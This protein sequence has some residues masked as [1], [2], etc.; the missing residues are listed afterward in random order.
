MLA[1]LH[2]LWFLFTAASGHMQLVYPP[3]FGAENNPHRTDP[4]DEF[5]QYPF[6]CCGRATEFPCR[7]Y[8]K[9]LG[10]P[11][12][13]ST[14][15]WAAGSR[16]QWNISGIGNHY[17]GS[18][19]VGFSVDQGKTFHVATSYQGNCPKRHGGNDASG[20]TFDFTVPADIPIGDA[21][22]AWTWYNREQEFN[23]NCAAVSI[24]GDFATADV[25]IQS[26][27]NASKQ[28]SL[29]SQIYS[30]DGCICTCPSQEISKRAMHHHHHKGGVHIQERR[31]V[32]F[33][34]RPGMLFADINNGCF[35]PHTTA[36]TRFADPG[37]DVV[38]GDGEYPL[39][40]PTGDCGH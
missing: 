11:Q 33:N 26:S 9:L 2:F 38:E 30:K 5:L 8:L 23:M 18:C 7:G 4:A 20:Q 17:G 25:T 39:E 32:S 19:Q 6:N 13:A 40:T 27:F 3:P 12:G 34:D 16:Q 10:T 22:F 1:S 36:E 24:T 29:D 35:T 37:P 15:T 31:D 14:A 21:I 28:S